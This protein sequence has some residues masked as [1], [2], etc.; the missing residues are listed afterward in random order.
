MRIKTY[1]RHSIEEPWDASKRWSTSLRTIEWS[2]KRHPS[3]SSSWRISRDGVKKLPDQVNLLHAPRTV[4][5]SEKTLEGVWVEEK[6]LAGLVRIK[7]RSNDRQILRRVNL[8][9]S[10]ISTES[11][12]YFEWNK[13]IRPL[14]INSNDSSWMQAIR[15]GVVNPGDIPPDFLAASACKDRRQRDQDRHKWCYGCNPHHK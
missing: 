11:N 3:K 10:L 14:P 1:G 9:R 12:Y 13:Y 15:I 2:Q 8:D 7:C 4:L 5:S 6:K